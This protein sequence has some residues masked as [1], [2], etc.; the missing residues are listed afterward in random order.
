MVEVWLIIDFYSVVLIVI[1]FYF[2]FCIVFCL[3]LVD[4]VGIK[5]YIYVD[6]E[7]GLVIFY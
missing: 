5:F 6:C 2:L 4:F 3:E 7:V 1:G